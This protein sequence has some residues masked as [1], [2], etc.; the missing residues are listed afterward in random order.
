MPPLVRSLATSLV[1]HRNVA[2]LNSLIGVFDIVDRIA[3]SPLM[4]LLFAKGVET[5]VTWAGLPFIFYSGVVLVLLVGSM[6][7]SV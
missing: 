6:H 4:A 5:G 1:E 2:R 7:V 3:G